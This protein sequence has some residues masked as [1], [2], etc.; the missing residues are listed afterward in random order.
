M[1]PGTL[2]AIQTLFARMFVLCVV[3]V[4][5][6]A[7]KLVEIAAWCWNHVNIGIK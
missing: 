1:N 4:P 2:D 5:L 7:W 3:F 6:G